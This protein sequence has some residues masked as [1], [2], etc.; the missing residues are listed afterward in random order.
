MVRPA[1]FFEIL[2][3][4]NAADLVRE[5]AEECS[6]PAIGPVNPQPAI[7][8]A[9][10]QSGVMQCF[11][12]FEDGAIVGFATVLCSVFP[13]Y[14][15]KVATVESLFVAGAHRQSEAGRELMA[16]IEQH[17][18]QVGAVGIL[19]SAPAGGKLERLLASKHAYRR[20]NTVFFRSLD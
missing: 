1:C 16:A 5:Y 20:T 12:A 4:P 13:H 15:R 19:Y 6:I 9:L 14:G 17:A 18:Q 2:G 11:A 3:A 8:R 7:Y 10:E